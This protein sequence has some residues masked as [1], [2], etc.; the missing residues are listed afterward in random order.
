MIFPS[1]FNLVEIQV[2]AAFLIF[3]ICYL[4]LLVFAIMC[5]GAA[6]FIY[7]GAR[8]LCLHVLR[9]SLPTDRAP[10]EARV[11]APSAPYK[12]TITNRHIGIARRSVP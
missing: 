4:A 1:A 2:L 6:V 7:R 12:F 8:L 10:A 3:V 9:I 5:L 11:N